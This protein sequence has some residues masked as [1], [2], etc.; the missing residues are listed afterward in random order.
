MHYQGYSAVSSLETPSL[1]LARVCP[2]IPLSP[3]L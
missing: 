1:R 2:H 3:A